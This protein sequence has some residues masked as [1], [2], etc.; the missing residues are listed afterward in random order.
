MLVKNFSTYGQIIHDTKTESVHSVEFLSR[1]TAD[2]NLDIEAT[3][4]AADKY[5]L[6]KWFLHQQKQAL[7]FYKATGLEAHVNI[8]VSA[9]E[10][11]YDNNM[12]EHEDKNAAF[13]M[14]I[15][16]IQGLPDKHY[17]DCIKSCD[18]FK[19]VKCALDDYD[20]Y[21]IVNK[22]LA[23]YE[24]DIIKFDK[25]IIAKAEQDE[26]VFKHIK[27]LVKNNPDVDFIAEGMESI[28]QVQ[29]MESIGI[30]LFQ[31]YFFHKPEPLD[32]L[33]NRLKK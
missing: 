26:K 21:N 23:D 27:N 12:F 16:Q 5:D 1:P 32:S 28:Y 8:D 6:T 15:T 31:G 9:F 29:M 24:F 14:E 22:N 10:Y 20:M 3:F 2:V 11:M 30:H 7:D 25:S 17:V 19:Y 18:K 33:L 4:K 13:T